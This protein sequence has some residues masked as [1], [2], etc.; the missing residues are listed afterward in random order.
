MDRGTYL[1]H[2]IS[3]SKQRQMYCLFSTVIS[4]M[5][6]TLCFTVLILFLDEWQGP[7]LSFQHICPGI[8]VKIYKVV[9]Y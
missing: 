4:H 2:G 8:C 3:H 6:L 9:K 1:A 7:T 5:L